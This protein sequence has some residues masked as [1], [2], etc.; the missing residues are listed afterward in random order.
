MA[1]KDNRQFVETLEKTGDVVR[2]KQEIDW[3]M[4][5]G[6]IV[7]R[8]AELDAPAPF[9][10]RIK[11]YP[12]GY[13]MF[14]VPAVG[15]RR[16]AIA[17]GLPPDSPRRA[18]QDEYARRIGH[19]IKPIIVR[20]G[21]CQENILLGDEVNLYRFPAPMVH[22]GDG[23][24][25]IG[26][27][28]LL[29]NKEPDSDWAN[30]GMYRV[31][32]HN[33]NLVGCLIHMGNHG[34]KIYHLK[35]APRRAPMPMAVAIG[36][37]PV[38]SLLAA[39]GIP[40]GQ[41]E[42]D[43]AGA[44][45]QEPIELVKCQ[46]SD[47]LVPAHAEIVLEGEMLPG[48]MLP[49]GPFGEFTG[50]RTAWEWRDVCHIKAITYRNDPILTMT[51]PGVPGRGTQ[52]TPTMFSE[53]EIKKLLRERGVPVVD[54]YIPAPAINFMV[55][56]SIRRSSHSNMPTK[57]KNVIRSYKDFMEKVVVVD[58]DVDIFNLAEVLHAFATRCHPARGVS[59]E[60]RD[61]PSGLCPY[62]TSEEK[63]WGR[64]AGLLLDSTWPA[65]WSTTMDVPP[66]V[67][68]NEVYPE[69]VKQKVLKNWKAYGFR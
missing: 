14:G 2:I 35:Y 17:L 63:Q 65:H 49:E 5:A 18:L 1:F 16:V 25:Y 47:L 39:T 51:N 26:S 23:G 9:F 27:W 44:L 8:G 52:D 42:A 15:S 54:V 24:R 62:L 38:S 61:T 6:A 67:S 28:H 19:P 11:G 33:S 50:Y 58:E 21:P 48:A 30:W 46:T 31:M 7:R 29:I 12:P 10:E 53:A 56:V 34:G 64:G 22:E 4:E 59:I 20:S 3:D 13:R 41:N 45:Q 32:I 60:E 69:E 37:D 57:V 68:F 43:Y 40:A 36:A 66:R 55:I